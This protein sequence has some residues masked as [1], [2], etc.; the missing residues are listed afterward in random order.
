MG[1]ACTSIVTEYRQRKPDQTQ[2]IQTEVEYLSNLAIKEHLSE[3]LWSF[4]RV[5]LPDIAGG[6]G[7]VAD[8]MRY[9]TE[10]DQAWSSLETAFS[11]EK[12]FNL[13]YLEDTS[14]GAFAR[15]SDQLFQWTAIIPWPQGALNGKWA[16]Y[17]KTAEECSEK[18]RPFMRDRLWP[19]TKIIR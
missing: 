7:N 8:I 1:V 14:D 10:S 15:I 2:S 19:F 6:S 13:E 12:G 9:R 4:R 5:L 3:Q 11:H 16:T 18:K 17:A